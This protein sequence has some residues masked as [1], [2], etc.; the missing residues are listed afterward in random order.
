MDL[1]IQGSGISIVRF[2]LLK[3]WKMEEN[4]KWGD[5]EAT[6]LVAMDHWKKLYV[7]SECV[8]GAMSKNFRTFP[9]VQI[10]LC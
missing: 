10:P 1:R 7:V 8:D 5:Q 3:S 4:L 2:V 9:S 6:A